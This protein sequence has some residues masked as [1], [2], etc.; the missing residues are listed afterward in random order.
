LGLT[1]SHRIIQQHGGEIEAD[2]AGLG[3]GSRFVVRLPRQAL[4]SGPAQGNQNNMNFKG[5]RLAA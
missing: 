5:P 2:S 4:E 1:I 3:K